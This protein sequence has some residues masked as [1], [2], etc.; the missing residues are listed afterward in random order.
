MAL[1]K[2]SQIF[3]QLRLDLLIH[4]LRDS[5]F[6]VLVSSFESLHVLSEERCVKVFKAVRDFSHIEHKLARNLHVREKRTK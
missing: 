3:L 5:P 6:H 4:P 1:Q 2:D